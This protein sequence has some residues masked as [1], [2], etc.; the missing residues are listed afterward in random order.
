MA[1]ADVG[2]A[3]MPALMPTAAATAVMVL[4]SRRGWTPLSDLILTGVLLGL[5]MDKYLKPVKP[6]NLLGVG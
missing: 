3:S 1:Y 5:G 2:M 6:K 4:R